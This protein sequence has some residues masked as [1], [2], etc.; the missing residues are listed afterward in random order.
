M[1]AS[2]AACC[3]RGKIHKKQHNT[4][5]WNRRIA[6]KIWHIFKDVKIMYFRLSDFEN[7]FLAYC[8]WKNISSE[9]GGDGSFYRHVMDPLIWYPNQCVIIK[10]IP[11]SVS[12]WMRDNFPTP[13]PMMT[14]SNGY[15][16]HVTG[17]HHSPMNSPHKVQWRGALVIYL[18]CAWTYSSV[19]NRDAGDMIHHRAHYDVTVVIAAIYPDP[20][21][22]DTFIFEMFGLK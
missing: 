7:R 13:H 14:S 16:F 17:I 12:H 3:S 9:G 19:Y 1:A 18:I 21:Y 8:N 10:Y 2:C 6:L 11:S 22:P 5:C 15:I 4:W 20:L